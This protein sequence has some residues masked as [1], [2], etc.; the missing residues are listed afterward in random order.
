MIRP[1]SRKSSSSRP[2]IVIAGV[3]TRKPD[4]TVGGRSS[5]GNGVAVHRDRDLGEAL[6]GVLAAPLGSAQ[7]D[8]QQVRVGSAREHVEPALLQR[9]GQRVRVRA[10][11][12]WYSRNG[13]DA[14][15]LKH[16]AFAAMTWFSGP[17]CIPGKTAR[18]TR[19]RVLLA[20]EDES[21]ARPGERLVRRRGDE[22]AVLDGIRVQSRRDEPGE[23]G[24][25]AEEERADLVRDLAEA[26][27][28]D[29]ARIRRAAADDQLRPVLLREREDV[30]VVDEVR[31]PRDAVVD[32]R[33]RAGPEKLTLS[34]CVRWPPCESSSERIVS[35]G[36]RTAK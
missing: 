3:P 36:C 20:A 32:D 16:A 24:H 12:A 21:R 29:R 27:G 6:L 17:P 35:P 13:S 7:V 14:A 25:V 22:V 31:L 19:L 15:I 5:N 11:G 23:V 33:R 10:N 30:V 18:S 8:E 26:P 2:R 1:T 9:L 34:P 28:L 4:A